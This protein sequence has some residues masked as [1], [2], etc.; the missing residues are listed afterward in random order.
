MK[1]CWKD[2]RTHLEEIGKIYSYEWIAT[3]HDTN[4]TCMREANHE[5][6]HEFVSDDSIEVTFR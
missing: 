6:D 3:Y 1:H 5:G 2:Y 4:R